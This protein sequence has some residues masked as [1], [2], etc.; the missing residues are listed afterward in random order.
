MGRY[1]TSAEIVSAVP[2]VTAA[3]AD[4]AIL[5]WE[6]T[7]ERITRNFFYVSSP[8]ELEFDGNNASIL[9]FSTPLVE[10]I[11]V[12]TN[13]ETVALSSDEYR[14]ATGKAQPQDD[15]YNPF[16]E[17][18][19]PRGSIYRRASGLWLK[20]Y[21]QFINAKWGFVDPDPSTPGA[22]VTPQPIKDAVRQLCILDVRGDESGSGLRSV[23]LTPRRRERTDDHEVEYMEPA[24]NAGVTVTTTAVPR[25]IYDVLML[26]RGPIEGA[27]PDNRIF[28]E[29]PTA[30]PILAY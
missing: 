7:V 14:A 22:Y 1:V 13:E 27:M 16:I 18:R 19:P 3:R 30:Y 20:G 5:K 10:V 24:G 29:D 23:G 15:R 12:R 11:S 2:G 25:D 6:A 21:G 26:Y 28:E 8:G 4:R 9:H 17:L